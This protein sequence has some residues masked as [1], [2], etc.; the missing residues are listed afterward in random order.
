MGSRRSLQFRRE[1]Q[2]TES[3]VLPDYDGPSFGGRSLTSLPQELPDFAEEVIEPI[4]VDP[5]SRALEE[6]YSSVAKVLQP[7]VLLRIGCPAL[8][9]VYQ[10]GRARDAAP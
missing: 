6:S 4:M 5:M 9:A 10:Q 1:P 2:I 7:A 8:L 3:A